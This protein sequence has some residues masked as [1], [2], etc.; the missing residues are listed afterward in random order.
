MARLA[1]MVLGGLAILLVPLSAAAEPLAVVEL[2]TSQGCSSCV[3]ADA[4]MAELAER[5][6]VIPLSLHVD[7][8]DYLGWRDTFGS[9]EHSA[10]QRE[11]ATVQGGHG[12]Y[13]PQMVI[14]G[15][16]ALSGNDTGAVEA[17]M[18]A[19]T[20]SVP[21]SLARKNGTLAIEVGAKPLPG[22]LAT[23]IRLVLFSSAVDVEIT[24]G[25]N[26]GS[27]VRYHNVVRAI[28]P[29][30]MWDGTGVKITL[31]EDE[32]LAHGIDGCAV[33]VQENLPGG[34]GAILGAAQISTAQP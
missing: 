4:Y 7:Y 34:P 10:R 13:T 19:S 2:F 23:T 33:I 22:R 29:I 12:V 30:G 26:A 21:I 11:Y 8:W 28:R 1:G 3:H 5:D 31:P 32:I 6:D 27:T 18:A 14:N 17:V 25:E 15:T 16:S 24:R 20:L 9:P